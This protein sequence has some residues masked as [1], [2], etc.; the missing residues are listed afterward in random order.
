VWYAI[1]DEGRREFTA[2]GRQPYYF[3]N[4]SVQKQLRL[5]GEISMPYFKVSGARAHLGQAMVVSSAAGGAWLEQPANLCV[6]PHRRRG[7][8]SCC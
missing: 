8:P 4:D 6:D 7:R 5:F 1:Q 3:D 2:E